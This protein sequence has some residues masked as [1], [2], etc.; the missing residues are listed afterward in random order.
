MSRIGPIRPENMTPEQA[1]VFREIEAKGGRLGGPYTAYIRIPEFMR[2]N[3]NMG[4]CLRRSSLPPRLR[5]L[6]VLKTVKHWGAKY[7]WAVNRQAAEKAGL[8]PAIVAAIE[9]GREPSGLGA[10]DSAALRVTTELLQTKGL[11]DEAYRAAI[12]Q[13]GE[14]GV[15]EI[16]VTTGFYSMVSMTLNAFDIDPPKEGG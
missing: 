13:F 15:A 6:I 9:Q 2:L 16:V 12:G 4:D 1:K 10:K 5:Q 3:Q 14:G 11:S 7:A 8:E